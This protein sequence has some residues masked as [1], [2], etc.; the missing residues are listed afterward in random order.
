MDIRTVT[1]VGL[2]RMQTLLRTMKKGTLW[3]AIIAQALKHIQAES[4]IFFS[5][6]NEF[7]FKIIKNLIIS[8]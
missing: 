6:N 8:K 7:L 2:V 4:I 1:R 5:L 3:R